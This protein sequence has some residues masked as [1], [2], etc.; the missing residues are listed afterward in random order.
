MDIL[1]LFVRPNIKYL[2]EL[3]RAI[4]I[5]IHLRH[6]VTHGSIILI[7]SQIHVIVLLVYTWLFNSTNPALYINR[8]VLIGVTVGFVLHRIEASVEESSFSLK[9]RYVMA[10]N[11]VASSIILFNIGLNSW[12]ITKYSSS[13]ICRRVNG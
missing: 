1:P 10:C 11:S 2:S 8:F 4:Y 5:L 12:C 13:I 6:Y 3:E 9:A 7:I